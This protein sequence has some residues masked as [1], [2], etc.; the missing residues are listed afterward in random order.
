MMAHS[1]HKQ[2]LSQGN[3]PEAAQA[4][5]QRNHE[6]REYKRKRKEFY[7]TTKEQRRVEQIL[8]TPE[9]M[10]TMTKKLK[11]SMMRRG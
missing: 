11:R 8:A 9:E 3:L 6:G 1:L 4:R 2:H 7:Q 10:W 5:E